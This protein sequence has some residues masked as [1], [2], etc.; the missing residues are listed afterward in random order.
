MRRLPPKM[1][2]GA[3]A[4]TARD[5]LV[6]RTIG[7]PPRHVN[8]EK[9]KDYSAPHRIL[10]SPHVALPR[11]GLERAATFSSA[12]FNWSRSLASPESST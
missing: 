6:R 10:E 7:L 9:R 2:G 12:Y 3:G 11:P 1:M 5:V 8:D 4:G